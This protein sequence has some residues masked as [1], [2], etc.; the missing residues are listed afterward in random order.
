MSRGE[1]TAR[2]LIVPGTNC[3]VPDPCTPNPCKNNGVCVI[4]NGAATCSC[5][6][7]YT[8]DRCET[9]RQTCG[10]VSRNPIGELV[11]PMSG[12]VYQHGLSCAWVLNTNSSLVLNVTFTKFNIEQSTD[13][14]YDFLQVQTIDPR[15]TESLVDSLTRSTLGESCVLAKALL[16]LPM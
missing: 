7:V 16:D 13:C 4:A 10:G 14:K 11:F 8:G 6:S 9:P 15:D 5:P 2:H 1:M 12:N 3:E